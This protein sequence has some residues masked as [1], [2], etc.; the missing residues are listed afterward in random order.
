MSHYAD[1]FATI[2]QQ[3]EEKEKE[4]K[5]VAVEY[6]VEAYQNV[7]FK[8][9]GIGTGSKR[10]IIDTMYVK[11]GN[12]ESVRARAIY[13]ARM[14]DGCVVVEKSERVDRPSKE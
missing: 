13:K 4:H 6:T 14:I 1:P 3:F 8:K 2:N 11:Q 10:E 5:P 9:M 7:R 12:S